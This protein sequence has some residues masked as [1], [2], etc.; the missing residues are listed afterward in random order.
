MILHA[1]GLYSFVGHK[2]GCVYASVYVYMKVLA[3]THAKHVKM[4]RSNRKRCVFNVVLLFCSRNWVVV[5]F[6]YTVRIQIKFSNSLIFAFR[7]KTDIREKIHL[8]E[9][10]LN[11]LVTHKSA[12]SFHWQDRR[13][14]LLNCKLKNRNRVRYRVGKQFPTNFSKYETFIYHSYLKSQAKQVLIALSI[15]KT[16]FFA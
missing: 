1:C 5:Q 15:Y 16:Y 8:P 7:N 10:R 13:P 11:C 9:E 4:C 3:L 2:R 12:I 14:T 6:Y